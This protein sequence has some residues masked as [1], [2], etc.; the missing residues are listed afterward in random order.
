MSK[1]VQPF[2][3]DFCELPLMLNADDI[4]AVMRVSRAFAYEILH[5]VS[6]PVIVVGKR[7]MVDRNKFKNWLEQ[8]EHTEVV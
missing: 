6:L 3:G 8:H 7:R 2:S 1:T 5:D 4:S